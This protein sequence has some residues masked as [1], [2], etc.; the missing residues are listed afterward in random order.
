MKEISVC[1]YKHTLL[2]IEDYA[3]A[4]GAAI[5]GRMMGSFGDL[6]CFSFYPT[7]NL[8]AFGD[9]GAVVSNQDKSAKRVRLLRQYG[10]KQ[11]YISEIPGMNTRLDE[12]QAAL[13][14]VKLTLLQDENK[15]RRE[16]AAHYI[17]RLAGSRFVTPRI[18]SGIEHV[19]HLFV[20]ETENRDALQ[21]YLLQNS[22]GTTIHYPQPIHLQPAY[23]G[24]LKGSNALPV[25]EHLASR[26]LSLPMYP[27][28]L[29]RMWNASVTSC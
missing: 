14:N 15:Q 25:T 8:G 19:M 24:R 3:Q 7:K 2:I 17:S 26:I 9:G 4:H 22:V 23:L 27:Q 11:R 18:I 12:S 16:I 1:A 20:I 21:D 6:A 28:C 29:M 10:W 5:E 13:L